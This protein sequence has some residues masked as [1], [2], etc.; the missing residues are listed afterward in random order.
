MTLTVAIASENDSFD[1]E[2]YRFL[3]SQLLGVTVQRWAGTF[4]FNGCKSVVK[5]APAFL[6]AAQ[7]AGVGHA[8]FAVDNDGGAAKKPEHDPPNRGC[9][10]CRS[11]I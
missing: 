4:A 3:L 7:A 9:A 6:N 11:T 10:N 8:L 1:G 5:L 2:V